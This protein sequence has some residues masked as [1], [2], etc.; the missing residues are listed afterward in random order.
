[1]GSALEPHVKAI[2]G[3]E[4]ATDGEGR[5]SFP[6]KVI[7]HT[8]KTQYLFRINKGLLEPSEDVNDHMAR[9]SC[10]GSRSLT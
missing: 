8:Q 2:F 4:F 9:P 7:S 1:M 5:I 10:G 6:K 3:C